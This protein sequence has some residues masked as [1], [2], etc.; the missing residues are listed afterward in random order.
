MTRKMMT[1]EMCWSRPVPDQGEDDKMTSEITGKM[2]TGEMIGN[3]YLTSKMMTGEIF[4]SRPVPDQGED[5]R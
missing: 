5:D 1:G 3:L 2:M 4:W